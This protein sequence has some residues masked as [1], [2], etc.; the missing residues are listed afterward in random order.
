MFT[1][2]Y[3]QQAVEHEEAVDC[4]NYKYEIHPVTGLLTLTLYE[5]TAGTQRVT[6]VVCS[7]CRIQVERRG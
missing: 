3:A 4:D 5:L 1:V 7:V 2:T 6:H